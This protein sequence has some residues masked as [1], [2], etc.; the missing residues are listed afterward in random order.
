MTLDI[1]HLHKVAVTSF[2]CLPTP[3]FHSIFFLWKYLNCRFSQRCQSGVRGWL[4][5]Y[6]FKLSC[7]FFKDKYLVLFF[8][9][10]SLKK[11]PIYAELKKKLKF[12]IFLPF[13]LRC[14][15]IKIANT[16]VGDWTLDSSLC[17]HVNVKVRM[18]SCRD[19][20]VAVRE[21]ILV[22]CCVNIWDIGPLLLL[23]HK[24]DIKIKKVNLNSGRHG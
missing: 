13:F 22:P 16:V 3:D 6:V 14:V 5:K 9:N 20:I 10:K 2:L 24:L 12:I 17:L 23:L 19:R 7:F 8:L 1:A 21:V 11:T 4:Y 18:I 15:E